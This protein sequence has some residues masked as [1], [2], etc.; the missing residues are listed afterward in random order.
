MSS[1]QDKISKSTPSD[2]FDEIMNLTSGLKVPASNRGKEA[3]WDSIM[4]SIEVEGV[5]ETKVV[6]LFSSKRFWYSIAST[7]I[8]LIAVASLTYR[9]S[10]MVFEVS[11]GQTAS[12]F[13]PDSSE[14][15]LNSDSK[16]EYRKY[17]WLSNRVLDLDGE[18]F[19]SVRHGNQ[20][21]VNLAFNR[22]VVVTGT[23]FNVMSRGELFEVKCFEGSVSVQTSKLKSTP[24]V[25]GTSLTVDKLGE[26]IVPITIDSIAVPKW[27]KGE[28]YFNNV[29][30]KF[31]LDELSRQFNV[32]VKVDGF[33]PNERNYTGFFKRDNLANALDLIC[34]PM[35]LTYMISV[36]STTVTIKK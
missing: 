14:I 11:R 10:T 4:Q 2:N 8:V 18:A 33:N 13:L 1:E 30:L 25:K 6:P 34:I 16:I 28:Y 22:K 15:V 17:G 19:F 5:T 7:I 29:S 21:A 23:K 12:L 35:E 32:D 3:I 24:V 9:Y 27:I 36:D 20:F 26:T 31:V